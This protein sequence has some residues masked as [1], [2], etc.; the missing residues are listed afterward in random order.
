MAGAFSLPHEPAHHEP[1]HHDR[2]GLAVKNTEPCKASCDATRDFECDA[3]SATDPDNYEFDAGASSCDTHPTTSCDHECGPGPSPP[4]QAPWHG[5]AGTWPAPP[6]P[7]PPVDW[8]PVGWLSVFLVLV[9]VIFCFAIVACCRRTVPRN[10]FRAW[11]LD[12]DCWCCLPWLKRSAPHANRNEVRYVKGE[13][14]PKD[15]KQVLFDDIIKV[16]PMVP[17]NT[18]R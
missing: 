1:A 8:A 16:T 15:S 17:L 7:P 13:C 3:P 12:Y 11:K 9:L 4:P 5:L 14:P 6:P 18:G 10:T 2:R